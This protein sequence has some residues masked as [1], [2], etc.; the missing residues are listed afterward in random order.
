MKTSCPGRGGLGDHGVASEVAAEAFASEQPTTSRGGEG[1]DDTR[2]VG[3]AT[4]RFPPVLLWFSRPRFCF[5]VCVLFSFLRYRFIFVHA[6]CSVIRVELLL[7][8][9]FVCRYRRNHDYYYY[10]YVINECANW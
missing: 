9:L 7:S 8:N 5:Y 3:T 6:F 1:E 10:Y 2:S 4:F